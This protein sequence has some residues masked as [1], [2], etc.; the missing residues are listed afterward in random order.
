MTRPAPRCARRRALAT[1]T[2]VP[3]LLL[4]AWILLGAPTAPADAHSAIDDFL[5]QA[6]LGGLLG[7]AR[8]GGAVPGPAAGDATLADVVVADGASG[9]DYDRAAFGDAWA[10]VDRN[11]CDTRNDVLARDLDE[12]VHRNGS[13]CVIA[14]GVLVD[15]YTGATIRFERGERSDRVQIDHVVALSYAWRH[16]ASEWTADQRR[17]FAN[18]PANLLA[19][20]GRANQAKS[21]HGPAEWSPTADHTCAYHAAFLAIL[22]TYDLTIAPADAVAVEAAGCPVAG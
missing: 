20:D 3:A 22:A 5:D 6:G 10:D 18:D 1:G 15:P 12:A 7:D 8:P 11:G 19:V 9:D 2:A 13:D 14:R 21:D 16:G 17:A 4:V